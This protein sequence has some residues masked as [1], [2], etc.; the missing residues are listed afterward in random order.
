MTQD[1]YAE[2]GSKGLHFCIIVGICLPLV[3]FLCL[4]AS[5]FARLTN[6]SSKTIFH[7]QNRYNIKH[8]CHFFKFAFPQMSSYVAEF[9][10]FSLQFTDD[11]DTKNQVSNKLSVKISCSE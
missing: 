7:F 5:V 9:L 11:W 6:C 10:P 4:S 8:I 2:N 3:I 1:L